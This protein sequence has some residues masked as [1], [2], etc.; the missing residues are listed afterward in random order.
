MTHRSNSADIPLLVSRNQLGH[1]VA[2]ALNLFVGRGRRYSIKQLSNATGVKDR[3]IECAKCDPDKSEDWRP[4]KPEELLSISMFLGADFTSEW[5]GLA[6]QG[7]FDVP[8]EDTP[9]AMRLAVDSAED[10]A[11]L[12]RIAADNAITDDERGDAAAIG[13]RKIQR[14]M[15]LVA[16]T[17]KAA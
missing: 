8:D 12:L 13:W 15:Q 7:A 9:P 14:G 6:Q 17:G 2:E 16:A 5:L 1:K 3:M 4:L 11:K 10:N